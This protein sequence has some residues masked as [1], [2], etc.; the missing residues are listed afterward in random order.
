MLEYYQEA[1]IKYSLENYSDH[2]KQTECIVWGEAQK[3]TSL[4]KK[5]P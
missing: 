3:T 4:Q 5:F 2:H 1:H